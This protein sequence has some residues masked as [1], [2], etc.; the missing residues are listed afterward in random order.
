MEAIIT[1]NI[2]ET[3][4]YV[5]LYY[6]FIHSLNRYERKKDKVFYIAVILA[7]A[8]RIAGLTRVQDKTAVCMDIYVPCTVLQTVFLLGINV[9]DSSAF[10]KMSLGLN[11]IF[12]VFAARQAAGTFSYEFVTYSLRTG[13][14]TPSRIEIMTLLLTS[15]VTCIL[16]ILF[17]CVV[18]ALI[19]KKKIKYTEKIMFGIEVFFYCAAYIF[20][21][22]HKSEQSTA[23]D[24]F[25]WV[26]IVFISLLCFWIQYQSGRLQELY[27][28][29][30][31]IQQELENTEYFYEKIQQGQD[32]IRNIRHDMKNRLSGVLAAMQD[33]GENRQRIEAELQDALGM[34]SSVKEERYCNNNY[35]NSILSYKL[36]DIAAD[37]IEV[38]VRMLY[39]ERLNID[40]GDMGVL[41]GNLIDNAVEACEYVDTEK[42]YIHIKGYENALKWYLEIENSKRPHQP[43]KNSINHGRGIRNVEQVL[44]KYHAELRIKKSETKYKTEVVFMIG[45]PR[46]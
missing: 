32:T 37:K 27:A 33:E 45:M 12:Y 34:I 44:Q 25:I 20:A 15:T 8:V 26:L 39:P 14:D 35:I 9:K 6:T 40:Y 18:Y 36:Q 4:L 29:K 21:W 13:W 19:R 11:Y 22:Q 16:E 1:L 23:T 42:P 28:E 43:L 10:C 46:E 41:L 2:I 38:S 31:Q 5:F 7:V 24:G 3:F 30:Q 17:V